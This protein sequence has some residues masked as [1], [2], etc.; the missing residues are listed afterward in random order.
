MF[1]SRVVPRPRPVRFGE[2]SSLQLF[3]HRGSSGAPPSMRTD[4]ICS[5]INLHTKAIAQYAAAIKHINRKLLGKRIR[6]ITHD[7]A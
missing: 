7:D 6:L 5:G 3:M 2:N 1:L 4:Q